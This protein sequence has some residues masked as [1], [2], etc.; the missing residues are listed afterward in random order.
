MTLPPRRQAL[1]KSCIGGESCILAERPTSGSEVAAPMGRGVAREGFALRSRASTHG[2]P[3]AIGSGGWR[4]VQPRCCTQALA[5]TWKDERGS[6]SSAWRSGSGTSST[7]RGS[8]SCSAGRRHCLPRTC[9]SLFGS[10]SAEERSCC[11]RSRW[12]IAPHYRVPSPHLS[13]DPVRDGGERRRGGLRRRCPEGAIARLGFN[14][15]P[16]LSSP[17]HAPPV[18]SLHPRSPCSVAVAEWSD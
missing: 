11:C 9:S 15:S 1:V 14:N 13:L 8:G 5:L 17:C 3:T 16:S 4:R 7:T 10:H 6:C 18:G 2:I 12:A